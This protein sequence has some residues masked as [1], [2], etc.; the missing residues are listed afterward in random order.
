MNVIWADEVPD[1]LHGVP[2][3]ETAGHQQWKGQPHKVLTRGA[4]QTIG[5]F[6]GQS[7]IKKEK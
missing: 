2:D 5:L 7:R 4:V 6:Q 1:E 3:E